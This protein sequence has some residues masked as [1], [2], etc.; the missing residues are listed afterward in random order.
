MFYPIGVVHSPH[1]ELKRLPFDGK[2]IQ[3]VLELKPELV[4]HCFLAQVFFYFSSH[5]CALPCIFLFAFFHLRCV[6]SSRPFMLD[7]LQAPG[8]NELDGYSHIYVL[9]H[10]NRSPAE[11]KLVADHSLMFGSAHPGVFAS[12]SPL[13]PN[14]IGLSILKILRIE[15]NQVFVEGVDM[16]DGTPILDIKPY[17]QHDVIEGLRVPQWS[18]D[19]AANLAKL[20]AQEEAKTAAA[21]AAAAAAAPAASPASFS[22]AASL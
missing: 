8:L 11:F 13:R 12:R 16:L 21:A 6:L 5:L 17:G 19:H 22:P 18:L 2:G 20:R 9:F 1:K 15:A 10:F 14:T 7:F 4:S 3:G